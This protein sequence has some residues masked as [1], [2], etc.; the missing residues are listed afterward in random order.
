MG[1]IGRIVSKTDCGPGVWRGG[2]HWLCLARVKSH[3]QAKLVAFLRS[4]ILDIPQV[5]P[6]EAQSMAAN[7]G[8]VYG[9]GQIFRR[10]PRRVERQAVVDKIQDDVFTVRSE[11]HTSE[12]QSLMR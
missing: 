4:P 11:E 6:H 9:F 8:F 12:L 10:S 7:F 5:M 2:A 1:R 3:G